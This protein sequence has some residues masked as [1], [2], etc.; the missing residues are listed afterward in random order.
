[1]R[2]PTPLTIGYLERI[3]PTI[4]ENALSCVS[5]ASWIASGERSTV[6]QHPRALLG[7]GLH[8]VL[9]KGRTV[10][11]KGTT[12]EE[13]RQTARSLFDAEVEELHSS[14]HPLLKAKFSSPDRIPYYNAI[15][16]RAAL[17][18]AQVSRPRGASAGGVKSESVVAIEKT[19]ASRDG[20]LAGRP[21]VLDQ[22]TQTVVDY[23]T[24]TSKSGSEVSEGEAR[25]LR[26]Y[27]YLAA[28]NN[29][30]IRRGVVLRSDR[31]R[32]ELDI[33]AQDAQAEATQ[34]L[35]TLDRFNSFTGHAFSEAASPSPI[36]CRFCP[37]I[38]F[39]PAFW[40]AAEESWSDSVGT[41]LEGQVVSIQ[42]EALVSIEL[43]ISR[44]SAP[45]GG[46]VV[47]RL[48]ERW[49]TADGSSSPEAGDLI[50]VVDAYLAEE[51]TDP[52]ILR[53]DRI[54]TSVWQLGAGRE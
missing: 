36:N 16:E 20:R 7:L 27:G 18:A 1:M 19:L 24:G 10:G 30:T 42:G 50:R 49:L 52:T 13:R 39:C 17:L 26:L 21:D 31:T 37:C 47:T 32:A 2:L 35:E 8:A 22:A 38:P 33:T 51:G 45:K 14:A 3:T 46:G 11:M 5:R 12:P 34:A 9:E 41:H 29:I 28:E 15:R 23:K 48:S 6:P 43:E 44:G 4:Y 25:Q 54:S 40:D 53:A